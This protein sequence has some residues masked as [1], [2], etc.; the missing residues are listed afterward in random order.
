V[1]DAGKVK[2]PDRSRLPAHLLPREDI[3][4]DIR[5]PGQIESIHPA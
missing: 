1:V 2:R 4:L 3:Q 5:N